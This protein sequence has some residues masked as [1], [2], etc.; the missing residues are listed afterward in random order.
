MRPV[1]SRPRALAAF[2]G[3][4]FV[5]SWGLW[6]PMVLM[7]REIPILRMG[8]TFGPLLAAL[9][10][11][12]AVGGGSGV[13]RVLKPFGVWRV[14]VFW[15]LFALFSTALLVFTALGIYFTAGG[16]R[17]VFND[18]RK[19]YLVIPV[20][21]YVLLFSVRGEETGWRGFA[22][23]RL[24]KRLGPL[25]ASLILGFLWGIWHLP[26]FWIPGN[27]HQ[28]IPLGLFILQD[29]ALAVVLTWI[30]NHTR[31]SLLLIHLF[32]AASNTTLGLLP[33]LPMDTGGDL[34][35]LFITFG[36]LIILA[37]GII[38]S[39]TLPGSACPI[40]ENHS[41]ACIADST[42]GYISIT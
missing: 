37:L 2:F 38:L 34:R 32:H 4:T 19:A 20:F 7:G 10:V 12:F 21:I 27:F 25:R 35:P 1:N 36:L 6:I 40:P 5:I 29:I 28:H 23:P 18:P 9:I 15:Y 41:A 42:S 31:G 22:L 26:L 8:G 30:Y 3:L 33:V 16:H 14:N 24:Q 13:R 17:L 39:G 11:T